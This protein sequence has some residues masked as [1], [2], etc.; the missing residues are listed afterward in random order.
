MDD[1][2]VL[3]NAHPSPKEPAPMRAWEGCVA[4]VSISRNVWRCAAQ[5]PSAPMCR[6]NQPHDISCARSAE[7]PYSSAATVIA[8]SATAAPIAPMATN[9]I[10]ATCG[11]KACVLDTHKTKLRSMN[12]TPPTSH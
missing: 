5:A 8:A 12:P 1:K 2:L 11:L 10:V 9:L 3:R 7:Q 6:W 4:D